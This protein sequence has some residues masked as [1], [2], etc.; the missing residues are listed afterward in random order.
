MDNG[1]R[2]Q[3]ASHSGNKVVAKGRQAEGCRSIPRQ[4]RGLSCVYIGDRQG[5]HAGS[6]LPVSAATRGW[7]S[8]SEPD[9]VS[10]GV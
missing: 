6:R 9:P 7:E 10:T 5:C 2:R 8:P 3:V 4:S 1:M